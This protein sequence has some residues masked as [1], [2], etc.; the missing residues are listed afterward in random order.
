MTEAEPTPAAL[1][2]PAT[3]TTPSAK[4]PN[5]R[6]IL[7]MTA[8]MGIAAILIRPNDPEERS[9]RDDHADFTSQAA[10]MQR[11]WDTASESRR[12][13]A[14][15]REIEVLNSKIQGVNREIREKGLPLEPIPPVEMTDE[16]SQA[17]Y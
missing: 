16:A 6:L 2:V 14:L 15:P 12:R 5:W 8:A 3:P 17:D 13:L 4:D 1:D 10:D 11:T 9:L 7:S